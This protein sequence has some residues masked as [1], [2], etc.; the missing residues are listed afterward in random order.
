ML[1]VYVCICI[2][3]YNAEDGVEQS[4]VWESFTHEDKKKT[5]NK[6]K[7]MRINLING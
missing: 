1:Y 7:A 5:S 4:S 3:T 2:Y 6:A